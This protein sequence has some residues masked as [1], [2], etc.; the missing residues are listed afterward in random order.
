MVFAS[1]TEET[2]ITLVPITSKS[3]TFTSVVAEPLAL[4][5]DVA[6]AVT[7]HVP[8]SVDCHAFAL[9]QVETLIEF[10]RAPGN[11]AIQ[12]PTLP[13]PFR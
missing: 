7:D 3:P 8:V 5:S 9:A 12:G 1:V 13:E 6:P 4:V 11:F 2:L 10:P